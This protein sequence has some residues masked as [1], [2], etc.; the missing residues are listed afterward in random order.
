[1]QQHDWDSAFR[2]GLD[3]MELDAIGIDMAI[4]EFH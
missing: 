1:M 3:D 4:L 2:S